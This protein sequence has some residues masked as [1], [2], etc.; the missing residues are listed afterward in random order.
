ML[1]NPVSVLGLDRINEILNSNA[2]TVIDEYLEREENHPPV[3]LASVELK[4]M[5]LIR[6]DFVKLLK[7][8]V[9]FSDFYS[10]G[11]KAIFQAGTLFIDGRSCE[12]CFKVL[13]I[14][15]HVRNV[16]F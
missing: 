15:K 4:K 11:Q 1:E 12:L 13:D 14:A 10:P 16:V 8:F 5:L 2:E 6:R 7:N 3:A 9:S